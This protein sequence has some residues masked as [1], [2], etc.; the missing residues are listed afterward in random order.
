MAYAYLAGSEGVQLETR[1][2]AISDGT[3]ELLNE[4]AAL[5]QD[6][7]PDGFVFP[8][9]KVSTPISPD[10]LW[11]R[12]MRP[13]LE[14]I[15][16]GWATF[17]VLRKAN[18]SLSKKASVDPK[19]PPTTGA[20][21]SASA[22]RSTR[23]RTWSRNGQRSRLSKP[24]CVGRPIRNPGRQRRASRLNGVNGVQRNR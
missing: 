20:T 23:A 9:E 16:M 7:S 13:R 18:A 19:S 3:L 4:W 21:D 12:N 10:N 5:A 24:P 15:G 14:R 2:G 17:Q 1:E 22:W 6:P 11:R 8:S